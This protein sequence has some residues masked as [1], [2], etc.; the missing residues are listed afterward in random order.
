MKNKVLMYTLITIGLVY[1]SIGVS[2]I[3]PIADTFAGTALIGGTAAP[4]GLTVTAHITA[5]GEQVGSATTNNASA[6]GNYEMSVEFCDPEDTV[7]C[8]AANTTD[9]KAKTSSGLTFKIS[10]TACTSPAADA[11]TT[12]AGGG[13]TNT[14]LN[15][16]I[17]ASCT[18]GVMNGDETAV[19]C[20]GSTCI[21]C[22]AMTSALSATTV[23]VT[24]NSSGTV[25]LTIT[26]T[27]KQ[28]LTGINVTVSTFTPTDGS[29]TITVPA[30]AT[31][32]EGSGSGAAAGTKNLNVTL[33]ISVGVN[34]TEGVF[35]GN[36]TVAATGV[37]TQVK[38]INV[39]TRA[40]TAGRRAKRM[41]IS[42]SG[43][44]GAPVCLGQPVVIKAVDLT[45]GSVLDGAD[46]DVFIPAEKRVANKITYGTADDNGEFQFT[47]TAAG[48]YLI[49][50]VESSYREGSLKVTVESCVATTSTMPATTTAPPVVVTTSQPKYTT[51]STVPETTTFKAPPVT[52][53]YKPPVTTR[54]AP[55]PP[56]AKK[57]PITTILI[58]IIVLVIIVAVVMKGKGGGAA[59]AAKEKPKAEE[60][61]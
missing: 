18:D 56:P 6:F 33:N 50:V 14:A 46:V 49:S 8:T 22:T 3:L 35:P 53:V 9:G 55:L 27:G 60:K 2:A 15:L 19:D 12:S 41:E 58:I 23:S 31:T 10:G 29:I 37:T 7:A 5:T 4:N 34:T 32:L 21:A 25:T 16:S 54:P 59:P 26:A 47:P 44:E 20:G 45:R 1:G 24:S 42:A 51:S 43:L 38:A 40:A 17:P 30:H 61:K 52:T 57:S 48:E 11:I 39:N 13:G 36:V 28:N